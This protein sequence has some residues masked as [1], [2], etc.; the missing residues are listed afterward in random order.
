MNLFRHVG[1]DQVCDEGVDGEDRAGTVLGVL[2]LKYG[3][4]DWALKACVNRVVRV[5]QLPVEVCKNA[6][7]PRVGAHVVVDPPGTSR[8][9][10]VFSDEGPG[11]G[12]GYDRKLVGQGVVDDAGS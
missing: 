6:C 2:R 11:T 4:G 10:L 7:H 9:A 8:G 12:F 1:D 3:H 5:G